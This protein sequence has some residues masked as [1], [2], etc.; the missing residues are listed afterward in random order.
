MTINEG[1]VSKMLTKFQRNMVMAVNDLIYEEGIFERCELKDGNEIK[2]TDVIE[3]P[4][5]DDEPFNQGWSLCTRK[6][7]DQWY[8]GIMRTWFGDRGKLDFDV[9]AYIHLSDDDRKKYK[10]IAVINL[11]REISR[12]IDTD[13]IEPI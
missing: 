3:S 1:G 12:M 11:L 4:T 6:I 13:E 2:M 5:H 8:V 10:R 7:D 9:I